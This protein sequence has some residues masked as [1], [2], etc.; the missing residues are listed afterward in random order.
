MLEKE[1]IQVGD[2]VVAL[3]RLVTAGKKEDKAVGQFEGSV[4]MP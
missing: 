3:V 4:E 1:R 2:E